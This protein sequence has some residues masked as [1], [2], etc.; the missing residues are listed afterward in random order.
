[1]TSSVAARH[2]AERE[3]R[4][5]IRLLLADDDEAVREELGSYL[6]GEGFAIVGSVPDGLHAFE[7]AAWLRPDVVLMDLHMPNMDGISATNIIKSHSPE[8]PVVILTA[9]AE[10]DNRWASQLAGAASFLDKS[11]SMS[12]LVEALRS[13]VR[14]RR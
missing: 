4:D 9:F 10:R 1:M 8:I 13:A 11:S 2:V 7:Q 3:T 12:E 6:E 5:P 14:G